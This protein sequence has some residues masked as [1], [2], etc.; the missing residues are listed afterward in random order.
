MLPPLAPRTP[1]KVQ[2]KAPRFAAKSDERNGTTQRRPQKKPSVSKSFPQFPEAL[3]EGAAAA[4]ASRAARR[5]SRHLDHR[6]P[7]RGRRHGGTTRPG[8]ATARTTAAA[9][10]AQEKAQEGAADEAPRGPAG[11]AGDGP[12]ATQG[13]PH[14]GRGLEGHRPAR[15]GPRTSASP[16]HGRRR[17]PVPVGAGPQRLGR[18]GFRR[19]E[20]SPDPLATAEHNLQSNAEQSA[21]RPRECSPPP[22]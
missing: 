22:Q 4:A 8:A 3:G 20:A 7:G 14:A 1:S 17:V 12:A 21:S 10:A 18:V 19:P 5:G 13:A 11:D 9:A 2:P 15:S 6:G 16:S